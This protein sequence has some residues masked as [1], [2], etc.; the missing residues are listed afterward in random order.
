MES[1]LEKQIGGSHY[2]SFKI[3]PVEFITRNNL[4]FLQGCIVKRIC[5][6]NQPGGKNTEDLQKIKHEVDL[7]M[8]LGVQSSQGAESTP[9]QFLYRNGDDIASEECTESKCIVDCG[10][11]PAKFAAEEFAA[12]EFAASEVCDEL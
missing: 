3:Q 5:R 11:I 2:Q 12:E 10:F 8:E 4:N 7:L 9:S 1:A 6:F